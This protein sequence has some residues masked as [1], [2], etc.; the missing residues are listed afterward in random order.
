MVYWLR[1]PW[2]CS[3]W[4]RF[5]AYSRHS[6]V[7]LRKILHGTFSCLAFLASSS[8]L[9]SYLYETKKQNKNFQ[10]ES[11]ILVSP[12]AGRGNCLPHVERLHRFPASQDNKYK[13]E[14]KYRPPTL[15]CWFFYSVLLFL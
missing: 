10:P 8:K 15:I 14:M 9:Q 4:R 7:S 1:A 6:V 13:D 2:L 3:T 5:K 11:N 12:E